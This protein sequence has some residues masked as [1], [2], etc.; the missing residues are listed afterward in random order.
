MQ[1]QNKFVRIVFESKV[2]AKDPS[3]NSILRMNTIYHSNKIIY[4]LNVLDAV[5]YYFSNFFLVN[6]LLNNGKSFIK[7]LSLDKAF[8]PLI[9]GRIW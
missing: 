2:R 6:L 8:H 7:F 1:S 9:F 5:V 4:K 3:K